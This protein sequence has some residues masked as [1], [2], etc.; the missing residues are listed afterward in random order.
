MLSTSDC[1]SAVL[2]AATGPPW[3]TSANEPYNSFTG[4][5][6][7]LQLPEPGAI[8]TEGNRGLAQPALI[9]FIPFTALQ[10]FRFNLL[11]FRF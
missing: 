6:S 5:R 1:G 9:P 2:P 7:L 11:P 8:S 10:S 3:Q 4:S